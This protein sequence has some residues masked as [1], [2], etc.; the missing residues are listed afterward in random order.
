[1]RYLEPSN[2][3]KWPL[4]WKSNELPGPE[5]EG[6]MGR[7]RLQVQVS[8]LHDEKVLEMCCIMWMCVI[9]VNGTFKHV[10]MVKF[11]VRC[12]L[13]RLNKSNHFCPVSKPCWWVPVSFLFPDVGTSP[14]SSYCASHIPFSCGNSSGYTYFG[15]NR[16]WHPPHG[17]QREHAFPLGAPCDGF[18]SSSLDT[19]YGLFLPGPAAPQ[20]CKCWV[21]FCSCID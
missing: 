9:P 8:V 17:N 20:R 1:M 14:V 3:R 5:V 4:V 11:C 2:S 19:A 21:V 10:K 6:D 18:C 13:P 7:G 16:L 12:F 15:I